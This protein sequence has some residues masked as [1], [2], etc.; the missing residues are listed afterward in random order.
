MADLERFGGNVNDELTALRKKN[1][2]LEAQ[3]KQVIHSTPHPTLSHSLP[4][5]LPTPPLQFQTPIFYKYVHNL[6]IHLWNDSLT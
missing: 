6:I 2:A 5:P 4:I 1:V 3:L